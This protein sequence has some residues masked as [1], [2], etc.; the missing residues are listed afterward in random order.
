MLQAV[1]DF[2]QTLLGIGLD[3]GDMNAL[4]MALRTVII[5]AA[6][7]ALV[8]LGSSRFLGESTA[9][10]VVIGIMLGSIMSRAI[11]S[12]APLVPTLAAGATLVGMHRLLAYVS[13]HTDWFGSLVKGKPILLIEDGQVKSEGVQRENLSTQDLNEALRLQGQVTD[14][15]KVRL[16][17][18]ER[19]GRI[20]VITKSSE[21]RVIIV[22]VEEG[23]QTVRI[24]LDS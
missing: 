3:A 24:E 4:Q 17:Y 16:A 7:L 12:S 9:F 18:R 11:N 10:D 20:S 8:R 14:P 1:G 23:V 15:E 19:N 22:P 2:L 6:S 5:Y 21:P 13:F